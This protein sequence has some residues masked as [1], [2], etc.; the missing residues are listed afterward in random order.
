MLTNESDILVLDPTMGSPVMSRVAVC[1]TSNQITST[2][3]NIFKLNVLNSSNLNASL[4]AIVMTPAPNSTWPFSTYNTTTTISNTADSGLFQ[5]QMYGPT[6]TIG[7]WYGFAPGNVT[8]QLDCAETYFSATNSRVFDV[9]LNGTVVLTNFDIF[10]QAGGKNIALTETFTVNTTN[11]AIILSV[12]KIEQNNFQLAALKITDAS[13][14]VTAAVFANSSFTDHTGLTWQP[15]INTLVPLLPVTNPQ[16]QSA[17][18]QVY[19]NGVRL[20]LWPNGISEGQV[21]AGALAASNIVSVQNLSGNDGSENGFLP[22]AGAPWLGSW[23]FCRQH[24]LLTN[25]PV[26]SVLGW[27]YQVPHTGTDVGALL[28]DSTPSC[29]MDVMIGYGRDHENIVGIGGCVIQ[30]GKGMIVLPS[31]P[32]LR[33]ALTTTNAEIT[34]PVAQMLLGN[35]LRAVPAALPSAPTDLTAIPGSAQVALSWHPAFGGIN[36]NVLRA[37]TS[38]G[39][40]TTIATNLTS[41]SY[42]D[43]GLAD[44]TT[45]YYVVTAVNAVGVSSNSAEVSALPQAWPG[46]DIGAVGAAGSTTQS[47]NTITISGAGADIYNTADAFQFASQLVSGD[48]DIRALVA[49]VANINSWSKAGVMIR[50]SLDPLAANSA[51]IAMIISPGNGAEIQYRS[52]TGGSTS[53]I[54]SGG[55]TAPYWVRLTRTGNNFAGYMSPDGTNWTQLG[56]TQTIAMTTN[57]YAGLVVTS[58]D[59][60]VLCTATFQEVSLVSLPS[61]W[62]TAD[63]GGVGA[64]GSAFQPNGVFTVFGSGADINGTADAFRYV[65]LT[66]SNDCDVKAQVLTVGNTDPWAKAGVMIRETLGPN[67]VNVATVATPGNGVSFQARTN[68]GGTTSLAGG[69]QPAPCWVRAVRTGNTFA[70]YVSPDGSSWTQVGATQTIGMATNVYYI[71]LTVTSHNANYL[72][73][74]TF[75]NVLAGANLNTG[76]G[77]TAPVNLTLTKAPAGNLVIQWPYHGNLKGV[78]WYYA[79]ALT[80]PVAWTLVTN[81]LLLVSNQWSATFPANANAGFYRLWINN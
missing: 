22:Q 7:S 28:L 50:Q 72:C 12:P 13:N 47:G 42:Q 43:S 55:K 53:E 78:S 48:C 71:G 62:Q 51:N 30:Y 20:V 18:N 24:W 60:G 66:S 32:G 35:A 70:G 37:T 45:Y 79:P 56:A 21:L 36:Y 5:N 57:V 8:V 15:Y 29:P 27:Q 11:G 52:T 40:Y 44:G 54:S 77:T 67:A 6:G 80:P 16:W 61:P 65:Y 58:H 19:S 4:D 74:A 46:I 9:A 68:T 59:N 26:N 81:S 49:S 17:L 69:G 73:T 63:I 34:Q 14:K 10:K 75:T 31:L 38:G 2:L 23:Y 64:T 25:L 76:A 41:L 1:E 33:N 39:P 3:S